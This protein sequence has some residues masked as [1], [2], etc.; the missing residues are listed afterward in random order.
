M[1][2]FLLLIFTCLPLSL[3]AA[4]CSTAS[5]EC[6]EWIPM[7]GSLRSLVYR[8]YPLEARNENITRA[9]V[10]VHGGSRDAHN[11]FRHL[12][13][14]AFLAGALEDTLVV[15]P[16]FASSFGANCKDTL[17][18]DEL[19]WVCEWGGRHWNAG[20]ISINGPKTASY[21]VIDALL[22][23]L[24]DRKNFPKLRSIVVAGHSSGGQFVSRYGM[25]NRMHDQV[26]VPVTYFVS[27][28][29]AYTYLD[30]KRPGAIAAHCANYDDWPYG[31]RNRVGY[32]AAFTDAQLT[33]QVVGRPMTIVLGELDIFPLVNFDQSC[34]ANAQ[35]DSRYSR[36]IAFG[37]YIRENYGAKHPTV[38]LQGCGHSTRC[39]FTADQALPLLFP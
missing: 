17:A 14:A 18:A 39:M 28:P 6:S 21:D 35:G 3:Q 22:R 4:P 36:G 8:S 19:N 23:R 13:A 5:P 7:E 30:G 37:K 24:A 25:T 32:A 16:R 1:R 38:V 34:L 12:M 15:S 9:V 2:I 11:N 33:K 20:G 27:N 10:V 29:G 31:L 26:G